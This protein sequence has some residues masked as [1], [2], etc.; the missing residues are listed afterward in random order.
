MT[1]TVTYF[2]AALLDYKACVEQIKKASLTITSQGIPNSSYDLLKS[3]DF[4][5]QMTLYY[6]AISGFMKFSPISM[7]YIKGIVNHGDIFLDKIVE[8][9]N[10]ISEEIITWHSLVGESP[11]TIH[12]VYRLM[13]KYIIPYLQQFIM[14][15]VAL[16]IL[17][18]NKQST[19]SDIEKH[20]IHI[21]QWLRAMD[22]SNGP[23]QMDYIISG[24]KRYWID[25]RI[26]L[27]KQGL[28]GITQNLFP[29]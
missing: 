13:E 10:P 9:K 11:D 25:Y 28:S 1:E 23:S 17:S 2:D 6:I 5:L 22:D 14:T 8:A 4:G 26:K 3:F 7:M 12:A 16:D 29:H 18:K 24:I 15:V 27:E 21:G 19:L 20:I